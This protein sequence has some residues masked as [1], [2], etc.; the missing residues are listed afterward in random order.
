MSYRNDRFE[1][2]LAGPRDSEQLIEIFESGD[3][4]GDISVLFTRRP[5][6][7]KSLMNDGETAV[8]PVIKE[9][10][11]GRIC[12][13]GCCI[14]RKV[15]I[16]GEIKH[17]GYLTGLKI[18]PEF[19]KRLPYITDVYKF[20]YEQ[21]KD[22]VDIYYT[23]ILKDNKNA[24][25]I[26]EK[27]RPGMPEYKQ[28]GEYTVYCFRKGKSK[29]FNNYSFEK[30]NLKSLDEFYEMQ[31]KSCNFSPVNTDLY[32]VSQ[33]DIF[34]LRDKKGEIVAACIVWNQQNYKQYIITGYGGVFKFI[35]NLP[36]K[37]LGYPNLP[38]ENLPVN[39]ASITMLAV[40]DNN[41]NIAEYFI[42]KV[43]E[44]SV[45]YDFL[46]LGLFENHVLNS[47][48]NKLKHIKYQSKLYTVHWTENSS[49]P[50]NRE[51]NLE[52]GLL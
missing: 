1:Y 49:A 12:A 3:F 25:K 33:K 6:P 42:K 23:T 52:V 45:E 24:Q 30:G 51:I 50:D 39:Y 27:N 18:L 5:D 14:I 48:L 16:N 26:L 40:K 32:G 44:N 8:I 29:N 11:T 34:T 46:M 10:K 20:L 9:I 47:V 17:A 15:Y 28:I 31:L 13:V 19:K 35:K 7:Y 36:L 43:A 2:Y 38:K 37:W 22:K 4:K 21:T 41:L